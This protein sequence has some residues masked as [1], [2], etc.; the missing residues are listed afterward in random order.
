[1]KKTLCIA[2][3]L[4]LAVA[5][6]NAICGDGRING[7]EQ[8]DGIDLDGLA[9]GSFN[10]SYGKL[11]CNSSCEIDRAGCLDIGELTC[12]SVLAE[13]NVTCNSDPEG[14]FQCSPGVQ[15]QI[16][17]SELCINAVGLTISSPA[18]SEYFNREIPLSV[19]AYQQGTLSYSLD[20]K[21]FRELCEDCDSYE[22]L[23]K[24]RYGPHNIR[25]KADYGSFEQEESVWFSVVRPS[26]FREGTVFW[27]G[28]P[29]FGSFSQGYSEF[30]K[31]ETLNEQ[32]NGNFVNTK[33]RI[34]AKNLPQISGNEEY[35]V[36]LHKSGSDFLKLGNLRVNKKTASNPYNTGITGYL[37]DNWYDNTVDGYDGAFI[38]VESSNYN[39][40]YPTTEAVLAFNSNAPR[41]FLLNGTACINGRQCESGFCNSSICS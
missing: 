37:T 39:L 10:Y 40:P 28:N 4:L 32:L 41:N 16:N 12:E 8:C 34:S 19:S 17:A 11:S 36:W 3:A 27:Y 15:G 30:R 21:N 35:A 22:K 5:A 14:G 13:G 7:N 29:N 2:I 6:V 24:Y 23:Y 1:M 33:I 26:F 9:C 25:V 18:S 20:G 38:E 31:V